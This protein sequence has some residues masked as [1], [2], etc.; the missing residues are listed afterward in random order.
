MFYKTK[1]EGWIKT[2]SS[3]VSTCN[4][5]MGYSLT[6]NRHTT[7]NNFQFRL[8]QPYYIIL[9]PPKIVGD[10][11]GVHG[12]SITALFFLGRPQKNLEGFVW[13]FLSIT[14]LFRPRAQFLP[15]R[16]DLGPWITFLFFSYWKVSGK[17]NFSLQ[18]MCV[19]EGRVRVD[20]YSKRAIDC[21]PKQN[22]TTWFLT[23]NLYYHN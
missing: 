21:K 9:L 5:K 3:L 4:C 11:L 15:I 1:Q 19:E 12:L 20:V 10:L 2:R 18:P 7:E 16:T 17:F 13:S 23:C 6:I 8:A 14:G 22:I